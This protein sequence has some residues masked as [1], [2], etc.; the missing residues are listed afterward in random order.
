MLVR[1][2]KSGAARGT[3]ASLHFPQA[4]IQAVPALDN[5]LLYLQIRMLMS[6]LKLAAYI[7]FAGTGRLR[8]LGD[9]DEG[10]FTIFRVEDFSPA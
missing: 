3:W 2:V 1:E 4:E 5:Y 8:G 6:C 10:R 7:M 9:S